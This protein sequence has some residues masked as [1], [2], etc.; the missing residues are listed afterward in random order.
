MN[1][2]SA[3]NTAGT[4]LHLQYSSFCPP[5]EM[6]YNH[7]FGHSEET[8][9]PQ[10]NESSFMTHNW[11]ISNSPAHGQSN[12]NTRIR[13][14]SEYVWEGGEEM[15][16]DIVASTQPTL[17]IQ[18]HMSKYVDYPSYP[19]HDNNIDEIDL[20]DDTMQVDDAQDDIYGAHHHNNNI[21]NTPSYQNQQSMCANLCRRT[22]NDEF[23]KNCLDSTIVSGFNAEMN[24]SQLLWE[25]VFEDDDLEMQDQEEFKTFNFGNMGSQSWNRQN[26][27]TCQNN[28]E[29]SSMAMNPEREDEEKSMKRGEVEDLTQQ[30][31]VSSFCDPALFPP[32]MFKQELK[33][34]DMQPDETC[35]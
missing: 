14:D 20:D 19:F 22:E 7:G 24:Q 8:F 29:R 9:F 3:N 17:Y 27:L 25:Q 30:R 23:E 33:R 6:E 34:R 28:Y 15:F 1:L 5:H 26:N 10:P 12:D 13:L 21:D 31:K 4:T 16:E 11:N 35:E 32:S 2:N 18:P